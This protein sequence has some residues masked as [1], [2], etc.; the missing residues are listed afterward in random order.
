LFGGYAGGSENGETW[1][2]DLS[3]NSWTN[4]SKSL[5]VAPSPRDSHAMAWLGGDQVL[6]FGGL[7]F[8]YNGETWVYD[9]SENS[10]TEKSPAPAPTAR[11]YHA[12]APLG[13]GQV[14]LFGG[15]GADFDG[16][17]WVATGFFVPLRVSL[18]LVMQ[19][20]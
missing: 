15:Y 16:D 1:V 4:K 2:Y 9:L 3:E 10:W 13:G 5:T 11:Y 18:P 19:N 14:L 6:L 20:Y 17:T 7:S 12:M 8:D